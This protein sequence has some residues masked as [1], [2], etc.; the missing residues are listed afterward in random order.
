[1]TSEGQSINPGTVVFKVLVE[2][3]GEVGHVAVE[4]T[5]V[6]S[7]KLLREVSD[8]IMDTDFVLW[9]GDDRDTVFLYPV[10][11]GR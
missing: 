1:M 2:Y 9:G 5:T 8:F 10:R 4:E 11:F 6:Q 3:T 7:E